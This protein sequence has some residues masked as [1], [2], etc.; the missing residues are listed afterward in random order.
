M[1]TYNLVAK[2]DTEGSGKET[3]HLVRAPAVGVADGVPD[4]G[5]YLNP[6]EAFLTLRILGR[7]Y[8]VRLPR[9]VQG[10]VVEQLIED[11][12]T[13]VDYKQPLLRLGLA[14]S[15]QAGAAVAGAAA[16]VGAD[17]DLIP[18]PTPSEGVFYRRPGPD[19]PAY[20]EEGDEVGAGATLGLV[21]VMK[22]F[23]QITYGGP[24]L[25]ER[26][27]VVKILVEDSAEVSHGQPLFL[28]RPA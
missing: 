24:A 22:S 10:R 6:L 16:D 7:R 8:A 20:V 28:I 1:P 9:N 5:D 12:S 21:E 18:V 4:K 25:P 3:T 15:A 14:E 2:V 13:P 23:N 26:G 27:V 19:S 17:A 11:T